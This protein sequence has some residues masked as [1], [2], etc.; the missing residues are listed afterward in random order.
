MDFHEQK[1]HRLEVRADTDFW[2]SGIRVWDGGILLEGAANDENGYTVY[3]YEDGGATPLAEES[4]P[5]F[6][7][8]T[9]FLYSASG[10]MRQYA[11]LS[12]NA[13]K[14]GDPI[15]LRKHDSFDRFFVP[16][17]VEDHCVEFR[18]GVECLTL[19]IWRTE[20]SS[21]ILEQG[22]NNRSGQQW[23]C[24]LKILKFKI[25]YI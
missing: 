15:D 18:L 4:R 17:I 21:S 11:L 7:D 8:D 13:A 12:R 6:I 1:A 19:K 22:K 9:A 14:P 3:L 2:I 10:A 25:R 24:M 20:L 5:A 23:A 16:P